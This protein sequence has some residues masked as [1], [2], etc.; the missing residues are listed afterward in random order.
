MKRLKSLLII[1]VVA[2]AFT[3]CGDSDTEVSHEIPEGLQQL[4]AFSSKDVQGNWELTEVIDANIDMYKGTVLEFKDDG[5]KRIL[6]TNE[7]YGMF[8]IKSGVL[9]WTITGLNEVTYKASLV[10]ENLHLIN[11]ANQTFIYKKI[12]Q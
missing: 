12:N 5:L 11:G 1:A 8:F 4:E 2:F 10:D 3:S 6:N 9:H 7:D